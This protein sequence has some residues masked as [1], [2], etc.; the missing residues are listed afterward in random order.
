MYHVNDPTLEDRERVPIKKYQLTRRR[1]IINR[2]VNKR[3]K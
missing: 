3:V 1:K 2:Q